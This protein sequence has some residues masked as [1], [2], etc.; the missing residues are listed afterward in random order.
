[1][2]TFALIHGA[3]HGAWCW[4]P[5]VSELE[6]RGHRAVAV[7]LPCDDP[8]A[9]T[10]D[11][12]QRVADSLAGDP[13]DDVVVV[14]HSLG[15]ITAAVIPLLRPVRQVVFLCALM[16]RPG[17]SLGEVMGSEPDT[18]TD[19]FNALPRHVGE[20]GSVTW[21]PDVAGPVAPVAPILARLDPLVATPRALS[22][23]NL[24]A[25]VAFV[26]DGLL[27]PRASPERLRRLIPESL[28]SGRAPLV[29]QTGG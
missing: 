16:P 13:S 15:G 6:R 21:D 29:F 23:A 18:T 1:M 19:A 5:L 12:A 3:W 8:A 9:T 2:T 17:R 7:D 4:E 14:G 27:D 28:P 26:R 20:G 10:M 22:Q 25:L 11:N 24:D